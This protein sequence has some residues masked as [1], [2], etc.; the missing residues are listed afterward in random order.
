[1]AMLHR[2]ESATELS[3]MMAQTRLDIPWLVKAQLHKLLDA[4]LRGGPCERGHESVPFRLNFGIGRKAGQIG[5][6]LGLRDRLLVEGR[7]PLSQRIDEAVKFAIR[8]GAIDIA[9]EF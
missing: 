6:T 7:D 1:M 2:L 3:D 4:R 9:V 8:Q 5:E